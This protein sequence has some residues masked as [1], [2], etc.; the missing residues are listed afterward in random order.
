MPVIV[1]APND[2]AVLLNESAL[3]RPNRIVLR[4][5]GRRVAMIVEGGLMRDDQIQALGRSALEHIHGGHHG[6][7]DS[8]NWRIG[9]AGFEGIDRVGPPFHANLLLNF[10][11]DFARGGALL[12]RTSENR[13][14]EEDGN[15]AEANQ[16]VLQSQAPIPTHAERAL[17]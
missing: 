13:Q 1:E 4:H 5:S 11:D 2:H 7:G 8:G 3:L 14:K 17:E 12:L 16:F 15:K 9:I 6:D 10:C